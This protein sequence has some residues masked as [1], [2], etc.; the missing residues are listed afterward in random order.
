MHK[1]YYVQVIWN[2]SFHFSIYGGP[3]SSLEEA[4]VS[5]KD[6]LYSDDGRVKNAQ[7]VEADTSKIVW[8]DGKFTVST[9]TP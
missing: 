6:A 4:I 3:H 5:A 1:Q 8:A 2:R 7:V 9:N